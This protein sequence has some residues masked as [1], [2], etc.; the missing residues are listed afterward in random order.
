MGTLPTTTATTTTTTSKTTT[1]TTTTTTS[2][3]TTAK[4]TITTTVVPTTTGAATTTSQ[5]MVCMPTPGLPPNGASASNCA[6]CARG[7]RWW[8]CN[9]NPSI[10]TC[11]GR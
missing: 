9:T 8:P 11:T 1:T 2:K 6:K 3:T 7:Y 4:T 5:G 10:C